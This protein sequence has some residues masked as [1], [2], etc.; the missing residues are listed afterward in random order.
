MVLEGKRTMNSMYE[1]LQYE[2]KRLRLSNEYVEMVGYNPFHDD[3]GI[4]IE[5]VEQTLQQLREIQLDTLWGYK[6]ST[7]ETYKR[8]LEM[9][10][11]GGHSISDVLQ[12]LGE[13]C[14]DKANYVHSNYQDA[15]LARAWERRGNALC[16]QAERSVFNYQA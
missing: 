11:D 6:M 10:L 12:M 4:T 2:L 14:Y 16:A 7:K 3:T 5:T 1:R 15:L 13:A 8:E 9:M